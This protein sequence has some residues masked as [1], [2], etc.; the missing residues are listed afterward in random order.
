MGDQAILYG[1]L[2]CLNEAFPGH[3]LTILT[4]SPKKYSHDIAKKIDY[5]LYMWSVFES[6]NPLVRT[7]RVCS[8]VYLYFAQKFRI[9]FFRANKLQSILNEYLEADLIVFVG[10]GYLRTNFGVSQSL[11]LI[12]HLV[13]F[14]FASFSKAKQVVAS[15][16]FG[17]FAY[18]WQ[19]RLS[20]WTVQD[21]DLLCV[22]EEVSQR[23]L[24]RYVGGK[25]E[26]STDT[27]LYLDPIPKKVSAQMHHPMIGFTIRQWGSKTQ[28]SHL[29]RAYLSALGGFAKKYNAHI[30]PIIQVDG[31]EFGESDRQI[32]GR[33][34]MQLKKS[35]ITILP[36]VILKDL[37][38]ALNTYNS[39]DI[40]L[41]MRMHSNI[42]AFVQDVPYVAISYEHKTEAISR[43]LGLEKYF[44]KFD[45]V[46][47]D[48]LLQVLCERYNNRAS[49]AM[50]TDKHALLLD[51]RSNFIHS[52]KQFVR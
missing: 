34:C 4:S 48:S 26:L 51:M 23:M 40:I 6:T 31:L 52:L 36:V 46:D 35:K 8:L 7:W 1:L 17:P 33:M 2:S 49:V 13:M 47:A 44:I 28:Q 29:E 27:A 14:W 30:Q 42:L 21:V 18:R 38:G 32:T 3:S 22:R 10:G 43:A 9:P 16:S 11:N 15:F 25:A 24:A 39:L 5:N 12:M 41:G 19:E 50:L 20:A 37:A 45:D